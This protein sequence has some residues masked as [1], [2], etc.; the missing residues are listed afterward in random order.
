VDFIKSL[1]QKG[2]VYWLFKENPNQVRHP[3]PVVKA[4]ESRK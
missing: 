1:E 4:S 3:N 2:W